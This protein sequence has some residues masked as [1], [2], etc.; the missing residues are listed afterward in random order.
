MQALA[1]N[2]DS[3]PADHTQRLWLTDLWA[4][5]AQDAGRPRKTLDCASL[6][7]ALEVFA[8]VLNLLLSKHPEAHLH[9]SYRQMFFPVLEF[10]GNQMN[11][12]DSGCLAHFAETF[13]FKVVQNGIHSIAPHPGLGDTKA[14][15][16]AVVNTTMSA[17]IRPF[18]AK[19][20]KH[21]MEF[22]QRSEARVEQRDQGA[23]YLPTG[24]GDDHAADR[25]RGEKRD[26]SVPPPSP[27]RRLDQKL[28]S[29]DNRP[30]Q[31]TGAGGGR[32][33]CRKTPNQ[34]PLQSQFGP[35]T[36]T[37]RCVALPQ[38]VILLV[39][40]LHQRQSVRE[41]VHEGPAEEV[42]QRLPR[43]RSSTRGGSRPTQVGIPNGVQC[44]QVEYHAR[45]VPSVTIS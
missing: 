29:P 15:V 10:M 31:A 21:E 35:S 23:Y 2:P 7:S 38:W 43:P 18:F 44:H 11:G 19:D 32:Q 37:D 17:A 9:V 16:L 12:M 27:S 33:G 24:N 45:S 3:A 8:D 1:G 22:N 39:P 30:K 13:F 20:H 34:E 41:H 36:S 40:T 6:R 28:S 26:H 25:R 4:T 14:R 42:H 5:T